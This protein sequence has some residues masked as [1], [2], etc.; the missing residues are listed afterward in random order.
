MQN[1]R[2]RQMKLPS[3]LKNNIEIE[4]FIKEGLRNVLAKTN[5][6]IPALD[7]ASLIHNEIFEQTDP[8]SGPAVL[9]VLRQM[10]TAWIKYIEDSKLTSIT[11]DTLKKAIEIT[12]QFGNKVIAP[13]NNLKEPAKQAT[14]QGVLKR[15]I[16]TLERN[17][18]ALDEIPPKAIASV[19]SLK[20]SLNDR[21]K[22]T[23]IVTARRDSDLKLFSAILGNDLYESRRR[24]AILEPYTIF[25]FDEADIF[26]PLESEGEGAREIKDLCIT[27]A[28]RGRKFGLGIGISTQRAALLNTEV[29]GNLHTY[30]VS[31]L[32]RSLDR[33][34]V[35]EA[36]GIG[37]EQLSPTFTFRPG[38]WLIISHDATGLKGVPIPTFADDANER[39]IKSA[40]KRKSTK[41]E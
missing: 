7:L 14:A 3:R 21:N 40:N 28:R 29:M 26:I 30:F 34:R 6:V 11:G 32:P 4:S 41:N 9:D 23:I 17:K 36:F 2:Y 1:S 31:K 18:K 15:T 38:N 24:E 12:E 33:Q 25:L 22:Q 5:I 8:R 37:E 35:T 39:I 27:L 20:Q 19:E 10:E 16:G 13:I